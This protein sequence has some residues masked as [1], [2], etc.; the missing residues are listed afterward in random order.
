MPK[1]DVT[2]ARAIAIRSQCLGELGQSIKQIMVCFIYATHL[3]INSQ[4][5]SHASRVSSP[6]SLRC[7]VA[8][9]K[10]VA[11]PVASNGSFES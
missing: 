4:S 10:V 9:N 1:P 3:H 8:V 5:L 6:R 11:F 2:A 7:G